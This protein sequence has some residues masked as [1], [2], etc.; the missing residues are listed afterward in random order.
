[1]SNSEKSLFT[2]AV[3]NHGRKGWR[4]VVMDWGIAIQFG[5][6]SRKSRAQKMAHEI[7]RQMRETISKPSHV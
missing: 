3:V 4:W 7:L 6:E 5:Y 1:M 2:C